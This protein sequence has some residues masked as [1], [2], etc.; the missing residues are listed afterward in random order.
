MLGMSLWRRGHQALLGALVGMLIGPALA[1]EPITITLDQA[2]L[3]K[4]P[5]RVATV[6]V[7]NPLI[8]DATV[9]PGGTLVI[10]GKSYGTTN[11]VI[12]DRSGAPLLDRLLQVQGPQEATMVVFRGVDRETY[13][14]TPAC[15]RRITLGDTAKY[16][17]PNLA[18]SGAFNSQASKSGEVSAPS[19]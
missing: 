5:E 16:F 4:L 18:H 11:L 6:V 13:S 12:L 3:M 2:R 19:K 15:E 10:T 7:G 1:L 9:Q 17:E 14:C 8:A